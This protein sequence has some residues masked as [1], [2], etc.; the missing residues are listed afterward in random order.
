MSERPILVRL[1]A[2]VWV[3]IQ[4]EHVPD[5]VVFEYLEALGPEWDSQEI[6]P[7]LKDR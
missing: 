4:W 7:I 5:A 1:G 2:R 6:V 3:S